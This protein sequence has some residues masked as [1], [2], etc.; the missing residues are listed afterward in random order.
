MAG[1]VRQG[2]EVCATIA[3][4]PRRPTPWAS[5]N[6]R[7][8]KLSD[9]AAHHGLRERARRLLPRHP[10]LVPRGLRRAHR[11]P[12]GRL[13][14]RAGGPARARRRADRLRQDAGRVPVGARP[15]G[16]R[17][18]AGRRRR[19][20]AGCC[21][22]P[23][24]R[25]WP[26]TCSATCARRWPAS[27]RPRT[28]L[29]LPVPD[30]TVGMR[31][32]DTPADE[33]R[34][35]AR[36][37][38]DVLVT[39]PESLFLLLTSAARESLRGVQTVIV[40]EVHAV[41]GTKRGAHLA[42]SL[43][44]LDEL[45]ARA[46]RSGSGCRPPCARSTRSP[47]SS[48]ARARSRWCSR[49]SRR[50][51]RCTVEVPVP[52]L[53]ALDERPAPG[54]SDEEVI[55]SAAGTAQRPSIWP[56]VERRLLELVREHRSTIVFANS[57]RL[58]ERLTARLNELAAEEV[59]GERGRPRHVPGRG[60][61]AVRHRRAARRP[62]WPR[63]TT[64]RCRASSAR[65]SRRSSRAGGCRAWWPPPAWSWASTWARSTWSSRSRRRRAWRPGCSGSAGPGHQVGAVSRGVVFPKYRGD[66]VSCA[67]VAERM[68]GGRDRVDAL[69]AQPARRAGP[70]RS[71]RWWRWSRGR[72]DRPRPRW[73]AGPRRSR[74]CRTRRCTS[75]LD[76]LAGRYPSRGVRRAARPDH[77]GPGHRR[78]C[79]GRPGA[80]RLA[81][82]SGGTIPDRGLFTVMTPGRGR[83]RRLPGRRAGRGDGL[84]VAGRRHV[85]ARHVDLAG[86]G[87]HPRPGD[88]H[89]GAGAAGAD[90]VLEGRVDRPAAGAGP[91]GRARS[92]GRCPGLAERG[93]ARAGRGRRAGRVGRRQP[94]RLPARAARGHPA[95][96]E[97][98]HDPGR[99]LPRRA[100][101]LAAGRALAVRRAGQRAVGAGDR[102]PDAGAARGRGARVGRRRRHRAAAAGRR[103][104]LRRRG[105]AH[106]GGRAARPGRG[107]ADRGRRAGRLVAVRVAVPGVRGA[108]AAAAPARPAAAHPAVAAAAA[109]GA[110]ARGGR[111]LRAVPGHARGDAR[112]R[113]GRLRP[114][115]PA[116]A[117][118]R[119]A[120]AQGAGGRGGHASRRRRSRA[121]CCSATSGCSS[122]SPTRRWPSAGP[123]RCRWT[124]RCWP[125]CSARRRSA[126]CS[127]RRCWPRSRRR[128]S[129][130]RPDR[131]A[132]DAEGAADLLRFLGDLTT[133]EAAARGVRRGVA[134][135]AGGRPAGD[136]GADRAAR[137]AGWPIEDAGRVRDA[138][139]AALPVGV[140][141]AFTEPVAD[142]LGDLVLRYARTHG[143]F[144]GGRVRGPV[145]ARAS[146][147]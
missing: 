51:S 55:G 74:R 58:A 83:R 13:G 48:P 140:P 66:L 125:S 76:M 39:T 59:G 87:H 7:H 147:W 136:P 104:R 126:S 9:P 95:R 116:R 38:P 121:A 73:C 101:R 80:Q 32:G 120:G 122:T 127:T 29:G 31:T 134:G 138:L 57:R 108:V 118:G 131:H 119:R 19:T 143:P 20:A 117:D 123:R 124:P 86:R 1:H 77:L 67:V 4:R 33:R 146:R 56:A 68:T 130:S 21:T 82:T 110:A 142:P 139:G 36:T 5:T 63:R 102:G 44:R 100:G 47:R 99:A 18:A 37:P 45:L 111:A 144:A 65:S 60:D 35:F 94:A 132:R 135:R 115:R 12:G 42:L 14:G 91:G 93:R 71:S 109:R 3:T 88:R 72:L 114:A 129:G 46:R 103:R 28:R 105:R 23:R 40:D 70:A 2:R 54:S 69:P 137:S 41:A 79:A 52:D 97:R 98:P 16:R 81:V 6:E 96:A 50:R 78:S 53:A 64:G 145:R 17:A 27:A 49:R 141:E 89:P 75:V 34:P 133:A 107:R 90:A 24:S 62:P 15:A 22:C 43:E 84:R 8:P 26:S 92:C 112:V 85:P 30:I 128:C 25:R 106:R 10:R 61:R 113:A 11:R